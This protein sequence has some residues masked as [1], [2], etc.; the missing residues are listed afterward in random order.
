MARLSFVLCA[1]AAW[2]MA[3]APEG[4]AAVLLCH[5]AVSSGIQEAKTER[6]AR[7]LAISAWMTE[8]AKYGQAY[9]AWRN[10]AGKF[11]NCSQAASGMY[12]CVAKAEPCGVSQ[13]PPAPGTFVPRKPQG[14]SG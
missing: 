4:R 14:V 7:A 12:Q 9:T 1:G 8:A 6:E 2:L 11:Y 5:A 10:A 13:V 3:A